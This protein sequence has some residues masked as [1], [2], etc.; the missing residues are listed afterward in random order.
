MN[1]DPSTS[2]SSGTPWKLKNVSSI[3]DHP[4]EPL[5]EDAEMVRKAA[6][7][8][9]RVKYTVALFSD[10]AKPVPPE[11]QSDLGLG[12]YPT[13]NPTY[14]PERLRMKYGLTG[15]HSLLNADLERIRDL[16]WTQPDL[17]ETENGK[18][19]RY[20]YAILTDGRVYIAKLGFNDQTGKWEDDGVK[21]Y[22]MAGGNEVKFTGELYVRDGQIY[23]NNNS[24]TF[25]YLLYQNY[26][27]YYRDPSTGELVYNDTHNQEMV[28]IIFTSLLGKKVAIGD[29]WKYGDPLDEFISEKKDKFIAKNKQRLGELV[30][31]YINDGHEAPEAESLALKDIRDE[32]KS[33]QHLTPAEEERAENAREFY[34]G[35]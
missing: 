18:G 3:L 33:A 1:L 35:A 12:V 20:N 27:N 17:L 4:T 24:A 11:E 21:H 14:P 19:V 8:R 29:D 5:S 9:Q 13:P 34:Q 26:R 10:A 32:I 15:E 2:S 16:T 31:K 22:Q 30:L 28:K 6:I 7:K 23:V 25:R